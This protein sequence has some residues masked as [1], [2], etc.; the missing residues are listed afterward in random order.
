MG[1]QGC[2]QSKGAM[3]VRKH[4]LGGKMGEGRR[5]GGD[6]G[7]E[8][9]RGGGEDEGRRRKKIVGVTQVNWCKGQGSPG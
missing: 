5:G 3:N 6:G 1:T 9:R 2:S 8:G 7:E 4:C